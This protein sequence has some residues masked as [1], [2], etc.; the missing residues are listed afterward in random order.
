MIRVS[1]GSWYIAVVLSG[2]ILVPSLT[3]AGFLVF[4]ENGTAKPDNSSLNKAFGDIIVGAADPTTSIYS[5]KDVTPPAQSGVTVAGTLLTT[6]DA[7]VSSP[8]VSLTDG[9]SKSIVVGLKRP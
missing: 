2:F 1:R 7:T 8:T 4:A 3:Q 9:N 5:V 6:G